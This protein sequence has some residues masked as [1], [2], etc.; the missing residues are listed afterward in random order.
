MEY[1]VFVTLSIALL[2]G[3]VMLTRY[4]SRRGIRV[5]A[6]LRDRLDA[7]A[8]RVAFILAHVDF[9]AFLKEEVH[10][11]M[12]RLGHSIATISLQSVRAVERLLTR[13][14]R[15]MRT[16][17]PEGGEPRESTRE[18]VK[19]LADFKGNLKATH[20]EISDIG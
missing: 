1:F 15:H 10:R 6:A 3:F 16:K 17:H 12:T 19:T 2:V 11:V 7:D 14:V 20:P 4:E 13:L 8:E 5:R 18:F 9:A